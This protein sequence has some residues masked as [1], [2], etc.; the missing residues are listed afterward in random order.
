[1]DWAKG[2]AKEIHPETGQNKNKGPAGT[3]AG[4]KRPGKSANPLGKKTAKMTGQKHQP[5]GQK[6]AQNPAEITRRK[7][8]T[9]PPQDRAKILQKWPEQKQQPTEKKKGQKSGKRDP[10]PGKKNA[11][12]PV[13]W[14]FCPV[15]LPG[16]LPGFFF[17]FLPFCQSFARWVGAFARSCLSGVLPGLFLPAGLL[18]LPGQLCQACCPVFCPVGWRFCPVIFPGGSVPVMFVRCFARFF[19]RWVACFARSA[20]SG[21]LPGFLPGGL[22]FLPGHFSRWVGASHVCPVFCPVGCLFCPVISAGF[23]PAIFAR[24]LLCSGRS[25]K[26]DPSSGDHGWF[27]KGTSSQGFVALHQDQEHT[28]RV[29]GHGVVL[30]C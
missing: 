19:A 6:T 17:S 13:G 21:M 15:I 24:S 3:H 26:S 22:A 10:R 11:I 8:Q 23:C 20:L 7:K 1:M 16:V 14:R 28:F 27:A 25:L 4:P 29:D 12:S 5:T 30:D 9:N 2:W 18:V